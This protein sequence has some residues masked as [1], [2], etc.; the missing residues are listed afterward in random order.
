MDVRD[1]LGTVLA[2]G[3]FVLTAELNQWQVVAISDDEEFI[4]YVKCRSRDGEVRKMFPKLLMRC[5]R[6]QWYE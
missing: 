2:V 1:A 3:D 5:G 6:Q 4:T